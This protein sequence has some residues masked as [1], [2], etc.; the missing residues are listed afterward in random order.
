[1]GYARKE[2]DETQR[3]NL[4]PAPRVSIIASGSAPRRTV[5]LR[6]LSGSGLKSCPRGQLDYRPYSLSGP[7]TN[8]ISAARVERRRLMRAIAA[9]HLR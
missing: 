8:V 1:M 9:R 6:L 5:A 2:E 7:G 4:R 3:A